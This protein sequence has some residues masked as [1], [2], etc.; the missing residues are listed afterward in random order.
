M[1]TPA[2]RAKNKYN[3]KNYSQLHIFIPIEDAELIR[4]RIA[5]E[6]MSINEYVCRLI[7]REIVKKHS[8]VQ[9]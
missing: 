6:G 7:Y 4:S 9:V 8:I 2:T 3:R 5:A 1:G